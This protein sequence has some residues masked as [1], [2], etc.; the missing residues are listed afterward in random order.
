MSL[1]RGN[2]RTV[3]VPIFTPLLISTA[4]DCGPYRCLKQTMT[5]LTTTEKLT[6][7]LSKRIESKRAH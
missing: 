5:L 6:Y 2:E 3:H 7:R 1:N 4:D